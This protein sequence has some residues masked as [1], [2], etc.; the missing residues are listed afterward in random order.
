[1]KFPKE[2]DSRFLRK[3]VDTYGI[4]TIPMNHFP[5]MLDVGANVG[6]ISM[7]SRIFHPAMKI[8][9]FEPAPTT[10]ECLNDNVAGMGIDTVNAAFFDGTDVCIHYK[11]RSC[12]NKVRK[13][14]PEEDVPIKSYTLTSLV[15]EFG[16]TPEETLLKMDC[17]GGEYAMLTNTGDFELLGRFGYIAMEIHVRRGR[18]GPLAF[19]DKFVKAHHQ[20]DTSIIFGRAGHMVSSLERLNRR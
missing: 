15:E 8:L 1:M 2:R 13:A 12:S 19:I 4:E 7:L 6:V 18:R 3:E 11:S 10:F 5:V 16:I 17:E 9:A 14:E 20:R